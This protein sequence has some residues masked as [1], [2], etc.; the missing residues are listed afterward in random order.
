M[1][2]DVILPDGKTRTLQDGATAM[3][4]ARAISEG[5]ARQVVVAKVDGAA[6]DLRLPL[7]NGQRV[8]LCKA[9][10]PE[11]IDTLRHSA[12]HIL[13]TA[14]CRL[15]PGAKVT[16]GP[17]SHEDEF[18]Y[19]FDV[20]KPFTPEDL[21]K[22]EAEMGKL[23]AE[24]TEFTMQVVGKDEALAIF[25][26]AGQNNEYKREILGWIPEGERLTL[27]T[28]A[29]FV[30]LCRGP[31]LPHAGFIKGLK[32]LANA[33]AYW[34]ADSKN[35]Q[36]QRVSGIA[37]PK[38]E[39]LDKHL[40]RVEEA[41]KRDHRKL[42]RELELFLVSERYDDHSYTADQE[43]DIYLGV[44][45]DPPVDHMAVDR[46]LAVASTTFPGR[47]LRKTV[48]LAPAPE[49][50]R[51]HLDI[52]VR[53]ALTTE[54][55]KLVEGTKWLDGAETGTVVRV[56]VTV[57]PHYAEEVGPGLVLW[58]PKGGKLRALIEEQ[59]RKMHFEGGYDIVFSPHIAKADLWKVSGHWHFYKESMFSPMSVDG[60]DYVCK[61]MNCPFHVMMVKSKARSYREFPMR[62]AELGTVY[63]YEMAGVLHGLMRVRGFTQDDAHLFCR[64]D[65]VEDEIDRVLKF[66]LKMLRTFGFS[67]FEVNLSTRP[68]KYVGK[69]EDWQKAEGYL[70]KAIERQGL[71]YQVDE[72]G[73]A[74][75]GPKIDIKLVDALERQW[76][77]STLQLDFNNPERF[78][79]EFVNAK[80]EKEE[81]VMLHRALLG[82]IERFI[83]VLVEHYAGALPAW[84]SP[85]QLRII[86]VTDKQNAHAQKVTEALVA[87]GLR[88]TFGESHEKLGAKIRQAQLEKIPFMLVVGD[89]EVEQ[90]GATVRSRDGGKDL[91]FMA[92]PALVE[93]CQ[94]ECAVP[95]V[96]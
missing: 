53:G 9:D 12:E 92:L 47:T 65:Q 91:G 86:T 2:I 18:Y 26:K 1:P 63:R 30:D 29:G 14:V 25:D 71:K 13:A 43:I 49:P 67:D 75:Y 22:I 50:G 51:A 60:H 70:A 80:G 55:R 58:L 76:Q 27:Y 45:A 78:H 66:I 6:Q 85:E 23:I 40:F 93:F 81:P 20:P 87:A 88:A 64:W 46:V 52:R 89:K 41:K 21:E 11:G 24:N 83:G 62:L 61:P 84:L 34:R 56:D 31:H 57:E 54:Q 95:V 16:M 74:F 59:W 15:F 77:C 33:G 79:L 96:A 8:E 38:K 3:D 37:F 72:G 19:D 32:V 73:G 82:S 4:L 94:K 35:K 28:D 5:L 42:G 10:S 7:K 36:L 69:L 17:K 39:D 90:G 68:E 48:K 44:E